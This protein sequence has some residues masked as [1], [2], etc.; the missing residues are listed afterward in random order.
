MDDCPP[1]APPPLVRTVSA[2]GIPVFRGSELRVVSRS[3]LNFD[4][5]ASAP[6]RVWFGPTTLEIGSETWTVDKFLNYGAEGQTYLVTRSD[7]GEKFAA[8][9]CNK[10][11]SLE[12][13]LAQELP[14]QLVAH[15]NFIKFELIVVN[16]NELL[17]PVHHIIIME[18]IPNGELFEVI[19]SPEPSVAGKPLSEGT[20]RRMLHDII[21]GMAE[22]YRFG[23]THR[24]LK[25]ENLLINTFGRIIIIDMGHAKRAVPSTTAPALARTTTTNPYGTPAFNAPEVN[26]GKSYDCELADVWSVGVIAFYLHGKLPA[27]AQGGGVA[28]WTDIGGPSN[29]VLWRKITG[30]GYYPDFPQELQQFIN[31]MWRTDPAERPRFSQL[32]A[33]MGGDEESIQQFPGLRWL[34]EAANSI[35]AFVDELARSCPNKQFSKPAEVGNVTHW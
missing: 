19:A 17:S 23:V 26:A 13:K 35:D 10:A 31:T 11:D 4:G 1:P 30:C 3:D 18:H 16:V 22:C 27:F 7:T 15:P 28:S 29:E 33:A 32:E 8:K 34:S 6:D 21:S 9:F 20:C 5:L 14:R 24:D 2:G 12:V 25:P